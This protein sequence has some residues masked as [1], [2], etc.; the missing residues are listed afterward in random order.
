VKGRP[1]VKI[2][3]IT[4]S[5][6]ALVAARLGADLLGLNFYPGSSRFVTESRAREITSALRRERDNCLLVG[7]FVDHPV[8][9]IE[10]IR[11]VV[12]LDLVQLHGEYGGQDMERLGEGLIAVVRP[13]GRLA[14]ATELNCRNSWAL[15]VDQYDP[16][17]AGGTGRSWEKNR[18]AELGRVLAGE[19][20][21][22]AGGITAGNALEMIRAS[23]AWGIDICSGVEERP[24]RKSATEMERLFAQIESL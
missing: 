22:L 18:L 20:W 8:G 6:D 4:R 7:V 3:G 14:D 1:Q 5:E 15:L 12:G 16:Q 10:R 19:R 13:R 17:V 23:G 2:C 9:E 11:E 21:F 24:G